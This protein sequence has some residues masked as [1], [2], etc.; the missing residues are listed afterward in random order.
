MKVSS[1]NSLLR[2]IALLVCLYWIFLALS[3]SLG[4]SN[5][6]WEILIAVVLT[7]SFRLALHL[8]EKD[9][10]KKKDGGRNSKN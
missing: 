3:F 7:L 5:I 6:F 2:E 10:G 8:Y 1:G 4:I 9:R